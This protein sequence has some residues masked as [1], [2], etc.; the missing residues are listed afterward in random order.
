MTPEPMTPEP[1][2]RGELRVL[3][4]GLVKVVLATPG[5]LRLEPTVLGALKQLSVASLAVPKA[6]ARPDAP[7]LDTAEPDGIAV[8]VHRTEAGEVV[9]VTVDLVIDERSTALATAEAVQRRI[10]ER[11]DE[12]A[13]AGSVS[14]TVLATEPA[15]AG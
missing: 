8:A 3:T 11:L 14:V 13:R 1:M 15:P 7:R 5:V 6:L 2:S 12:V 10:T 9:D 4:T